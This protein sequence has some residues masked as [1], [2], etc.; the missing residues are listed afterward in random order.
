M[1]ANQLR[2]FDPDNPPQ[3]WSKAEGNAKLEGIKAQLKQT[4]MDRIK[5]HNVNKHGER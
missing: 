1:A 2:F 5:A 3:A 4:Q